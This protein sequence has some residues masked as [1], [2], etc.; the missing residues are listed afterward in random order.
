MDTNAESVKSDKK[1][2]LLVLSQDGSSANY[3]SFVVQ[4]N[5]NE[6]GKIIVMQ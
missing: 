1:V 5:E 2:D 3:Y 4:E 6:K